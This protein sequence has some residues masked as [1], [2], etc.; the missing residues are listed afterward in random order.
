MHQNRVLTVSLGRRVAR[1]IGDER[2]ARMSRQAAD[3]VVSG[4]TPWEGMPATSRRLLEAATE[5]FA[6]RGYHATTTRDIATRVGMSPAALYVHFPSKVA[7]LAQISRLGHEAAAELVDTAIDGAPDPVS[8]LRAVAAAFA[9]W[10]AEHHRVARIVQ[11]E[12]A[13]LPDDDLQEVRRLRQRIERRVE[14]QLR[15]GVAAGVMTVGDTRAVAR[16]VLS[17]TVDV[18]RWYDPAGRETPEAIGALYADL[19]ARMVGAE[20]P[21][22]GRSPDPEPER[23]DSA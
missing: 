6:E 9:A 23:P 2:R 12:L 20:P 18:A 15:D 1:T 22:G 21:A 10:H 8:R 4:S 14:E 7:L 11:H 16:A 17:L 3:P 19:A 13:A 5:A